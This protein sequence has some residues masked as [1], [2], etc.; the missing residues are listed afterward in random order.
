MMQTRSIAI[1][2]FPRRGSAL[3]FSHYIIDPNTALLHK[4]SL[5]VQRFQAPRNF[6]KLEKWTF[7]AI[8]TAE[9]LAITEFIH[10]TTPPNTIDP[11]TIDSNTIDPN[12]PNIDTGSRRF[13]P[14]RGGWARRVHDQSIADGEAYKFPLGSP[15]WQ[16]TGLQGFAPEGVTIRQP[17]KKPKNGALTA[18]EKAENREISKERVEIKHQIGGI[19]RCKIVTDIFRNREDDYGDDVFERAC[20]LHHFRLHHRPLAAA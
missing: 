9:S 14:L 6:K 11:N 12:R 5:A 2:V 10:A 1:A 18:A 15:W 19:K 16:D 7:W 13:A 20:G 8:A 3:I 17:T 4:L